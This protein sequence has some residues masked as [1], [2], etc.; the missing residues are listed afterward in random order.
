MLGTIYGDGSSITGVTADINIGSISNEFIAD[1]AI[2]TGKLDSTVDDRYVNTDGDTMTGTLTVPDLKIPKTTGAILFEGTGIQ[3]EINDKDGM[4]ISEN[5]GI[6][7]MIDKNDNAVNEAFTVSK[8]AATRVAATELFRVDENG[9]VGIGT[10]DPLVS[11][12]IS[13]AGD[14]HLSGEKTVLIESVNGKDARVAFG[15]RDSATD[16][17]VWDLD[18]DGD[19]TYG[20]DDALHIRHINEGPGETPV[21]TFST[22]MNVGIGVTDPEMALHVGGTGT[23]AV[24]VQSTDGGKAQ[25]VFGART[26]GGGDDGRVWDILADGDPAAGPD[27]RLYI[28][29]HFDGPGE[30]SVMTL[31]SNSFVGIGQ[32]MP[33]H[34]LD[35]TGQIRAKGRMADTDADGKLVLEAYQASGNRDPVVEFRD[36]DSSQLALMGPYYGGPGKPVNFRIWNQQNGNMSFATSNTVQMVIDSAGEVGIGTEDPDAPLHIVKNVDEAVFVKVENSQNDARVSLDAGRSPG[37]GTLTNPRVDFLWEG[38]NAWSIGG[39][40]GHN[41]SFVIQQGGD[42]YAVRVDPNG[43]TGI[44]TDTEAPEAKLHVVGGDTSGDYTMKLYAGDDL[45][46]WVRKK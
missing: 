13:G 43:N 23:K 17:I 34:A 24:Y 37:S 27:E 31:T 15:A 11:V 2:S 1:G 6:H 20:N 30:T 46:A 7:L 40:P 8:N 3:G 5:N 45:A 38:S 18:A 26:P 44:G 36:G 25:V 22:N 39:A 12:H 42:E 41:E 35:V 4:Q 19:G 28:R 33:E 29:Y 21:M 10:S 9:R 14:E 32:T 16:T